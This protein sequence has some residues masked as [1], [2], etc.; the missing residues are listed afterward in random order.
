MVHLACLRYLIGV[1]KSLMANSEAGGERCDF[2][3]KRKLLEESDMCE[4]TPARQME[5]D[6]QNGGEV[7]ECGLIEAD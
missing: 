7:A 4:E 5:Q 6:I 2:R 3:G 1:I